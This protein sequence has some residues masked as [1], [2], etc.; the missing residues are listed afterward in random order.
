MPREHK[1][2][3]EVIDAIRELPSTSELLSKHD[4]HFDHELD[5]E[6]TVYGRNYGGKKVGP[7]V[8]LLTFE[9]GETIVTEGEWGG[10]RF[11][12]VV[13]GVADVFIATA[14]NQILK[15]AELKPGTQF[16]EMS[17]L[18]G[19]P[20]SATVK[21]PAAAA[22][23]ILEI[24]RPALR[25]LRK[26]PAFSQALDSS[27]RS[28]GRDNIIEELKQ[29]VSLTP[30][31][32]QELRNIA[33]FRVFSKNHVLFREKAAVDHI[34]FVKQG[35]MRRSE[36]PDNE[37]FL[38]HGFWFGIEGIL[39]EVVWPYTGTLM[40]RTEVLELS[41]KRLRQDAPLRETLERELM[42]FSPPRFGALVSTVAAVREKETE[43][44]KTLIETG[45]VDA[46]NLLV[47]DMDLCVRC[48]NCSLA[49]HKIHGQSRLMRHGIHVTRL[50][51][52][53]PS[54]IQSVLSPAVCMHCQDP[55][56]LTGCPTGAIGRFAGGHIDI[57]AKTC[58]GCGDCATQCPYNAISMISRK[59]QS[60]P[61]GAKGVAWKL[62][63]FL[64]LTPD[65]LPAAVD[66]T[67]DLLAV[68][69]NLCSGT[70]MNPAGTKVAAYGCEENCPTGALA[71]INPQE[72]FTEIGRIEGL[73]MRDQTHAIG[74]NIHRSDPP[75]RMIHLAGIG[76]TVVLAALAIMGIYEFGLGQRLLGFLNMRWITGLAGLLGIAA[77]MT[78]PV[79]RQVYTKRKGALRYW[80]LAH[81]Y[82]GVIAGIMILLHGGTD[83]GGALT[84]VLMISFD[85]VVLTGLFGIFCYLVVPRLLTKIEGEPLLIDDLI[86]RRTEL[87]DEVRDITASS[88]EP[89]RK[90]ITRAVSRYLSF[91]YLVK[92]YLSRA[93]LA[94]MVETARRECQ[95]D[96]ETL[97]NPSDRNKFDQAVT[98]AVTLRRLDALILL[99]RTLKLWL[100]PH[101]VFTSL[102]L[103][104]MLVHIIQ[105]IYFA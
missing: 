58:I 28:H 80:M 86:A 90:V 37:D 10:N 35:W 39:K 27:Y 42:R 5:L 57:D 95:P 38:G 79:R 4:G 55:E 65:P 54:A 1:S 88:A 69:C 85:L 89:V 48:G 13:R 73:M 92:Q 45:L 72:Y 87:Q 76:L 15:V 30:E 83:S 102:M 21:A 103:A 50:E 44:Q 81:S 11:F 20:R 9:P 68:K 12:V 14:N 18:A 62:R 19:V 84:T 24:Q 71:R 16:G 78:Y 17:V 74:R 2:R 36:Q 52:P 101:V 61:A 32:T 29:V 51:R 53:S 33:A 105:V 40:G 22:A 46:T 97:P 8:R 67:D 94:E 23:Q 98:A 31:M 104:L 63:D 56:C 60:A 100:V 64:R 75:R 99:H 66:A 3:R 26:L 25:L 77:V 7:Y 43:A 70:S 49:C 34:Y 47:M 41:I 59:G 82:A 96:A 6:V 93:P 91:G